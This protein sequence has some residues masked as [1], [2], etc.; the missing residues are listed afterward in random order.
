MWSEWLTEAIEK[1]NMIIGLFV[2]VLASL[3]LAVLTLIS[4]VLGFITAL[5]IVLILLVSG[6]IAFLF[7][8]L[9]MLRESTHKTHL[10]IKTGE[11][12]EK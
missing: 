2:N 3:A 11:F 5:A 9:L 1:A 7:V 6:F 8:G 10:P 12:H 4:L